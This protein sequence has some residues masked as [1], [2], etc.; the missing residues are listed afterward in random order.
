MSCCPPH[1]LPA[2]LG[3]LVSSTSQLA[4]AVAAGTVA[5]GSAVALIAVSAW[6]ISR[7]AEQPRSG[8]FQ[9]GHRKIKHTYVAGVIQ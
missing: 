5:A 6:L 3:V 1:P 4:G 7:A 8:P 2:V 9:D